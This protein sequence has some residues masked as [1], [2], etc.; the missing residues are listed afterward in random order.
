MKT[1]LVTAQ[2]SGTVDHVADALCNAVSTRA[3]NGAPSLTMLFASTQQPLEELLPLVRERIPT[4]VLLAA[5][6]A[7]EFT[8]RGDASGSTSLVSVYGDFVVHAGVGTQLREDPEGAV[9]RALAAIP[10]AVPEYPHRTA[11][12]LLDALAGTG[13]EA[14]LIAASLLGENVP[15]AGGAA[16]D[17]LQMKA[18]WVG[19]GSYAAT[20]ALTLAVIFSKKPLGIGVCHGHSPRSQPIKVTA[21]SGGTVMQLNGRPAWDVYREHVKM[22]LPADAPDPNTLSS[23]ALGALLLQF[24]AGLANGDETKVRAPLTRNEDGSM[25]F[26]CGIPEG[27][28]IRITESTADLQVASARSAAERALQRAGGGRQAGAIVFDCICRRLILGERFDTAVKEMSTALGG[29][30]LAG[31]ETYGEIALDAGDMS[32]FHNTTTVVLTFPE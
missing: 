28:E 14:T 32:G 5:S 26:A 8:E 19:C 24:E 30:P 12:L 10:G 29:V 22:L 16:G 20:N 15:L 27:A 7:G 11:V 6:T 21:S 4:G 23:D 18:T 2:A 17:G 25:G 31:F 3:S 13:E 1:E 9:R